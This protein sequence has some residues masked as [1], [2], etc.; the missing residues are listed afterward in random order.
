MQSI[1]VLL[2]AFVAVFVAALVVYVPLM[3]SIRIRTR[4]YLNRRRRQKFR[5]EVVA[6]IARRDSIGAR[7]AME[8][9]VDAV[10]AFLFEK[11]FA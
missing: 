3:E 10:T 4:I 7:R 2:I 8:K 1:A 11:P 5:R 9:H 6:C